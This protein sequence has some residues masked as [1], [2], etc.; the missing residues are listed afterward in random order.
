MKKKIAF[1]D[2]KPY[3]KE[4]FDKVNREYKFE[5]DYFNNRLNRHTAGLSTGFDVICAFVNDDI[6]RNT[7]EV[8]KKNGIKLIA[9][10]CSGYNNVDLKAVYGNIHVV[11]VPAYSPYAVADP[12]RGRR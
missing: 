11:R 10:R 2:T 6:D 4:F 1:F 7:V 5:I 12:A 3:D 9:M 8:L